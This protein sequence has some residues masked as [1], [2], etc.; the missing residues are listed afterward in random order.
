MKGLKFMPKNYME[1][2]IEN[3]LPIV[4]EKYKTE[5]I[6][7]CEKCIED[8]KAF[9]LNQLDPIYVTTKKGNLYAKLNEVNTQFNADVINEI[10]NA[11]EIVK[12]NPNHF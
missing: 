4:L 3:L 10:I 6:C 9:A 7:T 5:H 1:E 11:I 12:N 8:I 2:V